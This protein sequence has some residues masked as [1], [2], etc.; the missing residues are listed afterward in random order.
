M[1]EKNARQT[2]VFKPLEGRRIILGVS[3]GIAAYKAAEYARNLINLGALVKV[4]LTENGAKFISP[5]TFS[6]LT[7]DRCVTSMFDEKA[8]SPIPHIS[9]A[10]WGELLLVLPATADVIGKTACGIADDLL[11]TLFLAFKGKRILFPAMNPVMY[12]NPAVQDNISRLK[13]RG[14]SVADPDD[15]TVA[16]GDTGKGRLPHFEMVLYSVRQALSRQDLGDMNVLVTSGPTREPIDPVRFIS[17]RSSGKMGLALANISSIRGARVRLI[18]GPTCLPPPGHVSI[19]MVERAD[20]MA[21]E[22]LSRASGMDVV[23]MAAAVSDYAPCSYS[24]SKLKKSDEKIVLELGKTR[25]ILL[26]LGKI[27]TPGQILVGFC[28]ETE[29]LVENAFTKLRRKNLDLIVANDVT[30]PGAGFDWDTNKVC[31]I[32]Q[33]KNVEELPLLHKEEVADRIFDKVL[34]LRSKAS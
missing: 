1:K 28:A 19:D 30:E 14:I 22:V 7:G 3:G 15:G 17:N 10:R 8:K 13:D 32:D 20:E 12:N 29:N 16:C 25:D 26:E 23:V 4:V 6:A 31:L 2:H 21:K 11:T 34:E 9:I 33:E 18:T 5:L 27:K 24:D